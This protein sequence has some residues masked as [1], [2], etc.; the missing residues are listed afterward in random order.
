M[1]TIEVENHQSFT[2]MQ[3]CILVP[4]AILHYDKLIQVWHLHLNDKLFTNWTY[5]INDKV[6]INVCVYMVAFLF[7]RCHSLTH[8]GDI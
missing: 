5:H 3:M 7:N 2:I 1:Y 8:F 6:H 4:K